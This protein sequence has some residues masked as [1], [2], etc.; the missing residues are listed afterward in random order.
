MDEATK[1]SFRGSMREKLQQYIKQKTAMFTRWEVE[2][3]QMDDLIV[4]LAEL[5]GSFK[6]AENILTY[7]NAETNNEK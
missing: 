2:K 1:A 4:L 3:E 6:D 5:C 7:K